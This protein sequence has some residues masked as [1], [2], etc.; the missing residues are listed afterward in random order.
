[1]HERAVPVHESGSGLHKLAYPKGAETHAAGQSLARILYLAMA[2]ILGDDALGVL[3]RLANADEPLGSDPRAEAIADAAPVDVIGSTP[4]SRL[5]QTLEAVYGPLGGPG[6]ALRIG[7]A[8]FRHG[9]RDSATFGGPQ[10]PA[11]RLMPLHARIRTGIESIMKAL[12]ERADQNL[13]LEDEAGR[14]VLLM[15]DCPLC[16]QRETDKPICYLTMGV[17][18][19]ALY[20]L[21]GGQFF[22]VEETACLARGDSA[23]RFLVDQIPVS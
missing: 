15:D 4:V 11:F 18:Q 6:L 13:R 14:L 23:C 7:G 17:L 22:R 3:L 16:T 12:N 20:W 8:G 2:E 10:D 5:L 21:S 19:E 1:M 9:L